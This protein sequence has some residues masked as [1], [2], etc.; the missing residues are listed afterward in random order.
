MKSNPLAFCIVPLAL[1]YLQNTSQAKMSPREIYRNFSKGVVVI[2]ASPKGSASASA[3][4]GSIIKNNGTIITN[5]H[6][7]YNEK[8][9]SPFRQISVF[10]KPEKVTGDLNRD[11]KHHYYA[12][13][14][15]FDQA[16]DLALLKIQNPPADLTVIA[17]GNPDDLGPGDETLA[18][19]HPEQGGL[20]TIT[21]GVIG[22]QFDDFKGIPGKH[23]FQ[24]DTSLNRGNSGGPLFDT[25]G[26]QIGVNTSIA[27]EGKGGV[28]ITGINFSIKSSVV[29]K[30]A[31]NQNMH[32][33]YDSAHFTSTQTH[34]LK[35][36]SVDTQ[37]TIPTDRLPDKREKQG[38]VFRDPEGGGVIYLED[39]PKNQLE[40][41][42]TPDTKPINTKTLSVHKKPSRRNPY[43]FDDFF[44][45]KS[46]PYRFRH[47][48][49]AVDRIKKRS[50]EA[51][52]DLEREA[53]RRR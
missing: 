16:L 46:R 50:Q 10:L 23:V 43:K 33:S 29:K 32:L 28:V 9:K 17:L 19:G 31:A 18:I 41:T 39:D 47:L 14:I 53:D 37:K 4:T 48:F 34:Q 5:S 27:R 3:G 24:I 7:I 36:A 25:R 44:R 38:K 8:T 13:V 12:K 52:D 22:A 51:F 49:K 42:K 2:V 26:L 15:N 30:W 6:V 45:P 20:W 35:T 21:T 11:L 40:T 1:F